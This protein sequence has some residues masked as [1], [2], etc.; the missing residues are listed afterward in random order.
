MVRIG[1]LQRKI[2]GASS[3]GYSNLARRHNHELA[4]GQLVRVLVE[5]LI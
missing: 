4:G 3:T 5:R 2:S 1:R